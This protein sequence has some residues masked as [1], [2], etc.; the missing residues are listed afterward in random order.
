MPDQIEVN[1]LNIDID[2]IKDEIKVVTFRLN[3]G[4]FGVDV[5]QVTTV[6]T[7]NKITSIPK[8]PE[9]VM[10]VISLR[11]QIITVIDLKKRLQIG[12]MA[13][14]NKGDDELIIL[15]IEF[16]GKKIGMAVDSVESVMT[17]PLAKIETRVDLIS[18]DIHS[19]FLRGIVKFASDY[20]VVLLNLNA[21]LSEY[22]VSQL[23]QMQTTIAEDVFTSD[24][25]VVLTNEEIKQLD[26]NNEASDEITKA[27]RLSTA[28][29][30]KKKG[31][32]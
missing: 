6:Y 10:G 12:A 18:K 9:H 14:D 26:I 31:S 24:E 28:E 30:S 29:K 27:V 3:D 15:V 7:A 16:G 22:E 23:A 19:F 8:S 4:Y 2:E 17:V 1:R 11:G 32:K 25:E 20:L 21:V 5:R 13:F